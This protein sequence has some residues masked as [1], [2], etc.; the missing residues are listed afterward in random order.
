MR[1]K[2][3]L[4][5][6][7]LPFQAADLWRSRGLA[8]AFGQTMASEGSSGARRTRL[9]SEGTSLSGAGGRGG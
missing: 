1:G 2:T 8:P 3:G 4:Q 9:R 6:G 5:V 7:S